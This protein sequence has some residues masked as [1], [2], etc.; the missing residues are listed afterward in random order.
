LAAYSRAFSFVEVNSTFYQMPQLKEVAN[1]RKMVPPD[2][3]FSVRAHRSITH[4]HEL[5]PRPEAREAID[6]MKQICNTLKADILHLQ[7]PASFKPTPTAMNNLRDLVSST[8]LGE[9]RLALEIRGTN[10]SKLPAALSKFMQSNN[11]IHCTDLSKGEMPAYNS[12]V[13]YTRLFGRGEHNKYQP[14]DGELVE[15]DDKASSSN[16]QKVVMSFH[17]VRMYKDAARL[18]I[19]K[20]TGKF[21]HITGSTGLTSLEQVL[22]E[23]TSFPSTKQELVHRQGWKLFDLTE[24]KRVPASDFLQQLPDKTYNSVKEITNNLEL[25]MR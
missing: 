19:Y 9:L 20:Q 4:R 23:D 5:Q 17:F 12:D 1:W 16:F 25:I 18:K 14:T 21:P 2:F 7:M 15:I 13:L 24:D 22:S 11:V 3:Q 6:K 10:P 8:D